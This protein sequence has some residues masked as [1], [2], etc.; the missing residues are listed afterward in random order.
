MNHQSKS[1]HMLVFAQ[2]I[3][4]SS[5]QTSTE[6]NFYS[7]LHKFLSDK[8]PI[9]HLYPKLVYAISGKQNPNV[10]SGG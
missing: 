10:G 6:K 7:I 2:F 3:N 1:K 4:T 8:Q 5:Q 9:K